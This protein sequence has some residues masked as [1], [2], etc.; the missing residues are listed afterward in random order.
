MQLLVNIDVEDLDRGIEFYS[1][2]FGF[3]LE[4]RLFNDTVVE[5]LGSTSRIYLLLKRAGTIPFAS[6][7]RAR[8]YHRHWTPVHLDFVV[9]DIAAT[10]DRAIAA[11][12]RLEHGIQSQ[13]WGQLATMSDPFG[14]GFCLV[15]FVGSEYEAVA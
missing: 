8:D 1:A 7:T 10:V 15:Q 13:K 14:H 2:A 11:G 9:D 4:R 5:L 6:A 3:R 12:A